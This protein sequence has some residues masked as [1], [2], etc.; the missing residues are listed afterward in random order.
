M[1][2]Q[3]IKRGPKTW[4]VRIF[5]GRN[6]EGKRLYQNQ[7]IHGTRKNAQNWLNDA[8]VK[9]DLG[10]PTFQTKVS[11]GDFLQSWLDTVAK[12]RVSE[13]TYD[14]YVWQLAHVKTRLGKVR[15]SQLR[16]ED[17]QK[18]YSELTTSTAR[19]V[20]APLRSAL[21]QAVKWHLIHFNPCDSA[22]LPKHQA[23]EMYALTKDQAARFLAVEGKYRALF[24]FAI[25]T[26]ARPSE[27]LAL[28]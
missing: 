6:S 19:H 22:D 20:H 3:I 1:A 13:R 24:A 5:L 16:A 27:I 4:L 15:L 12:P 11:L 2:G 18:L 17:I 14:S 23:R 9:Q 7:T 10:I 21:S 28:K 25:S 8:L 26:G